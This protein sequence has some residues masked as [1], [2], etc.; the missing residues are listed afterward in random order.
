VPEDK[1]RPDITPKGLLIAEVTLQANGIQDLADQ[2]PDIVK[3]AV[4]QDLR[5]HVRIEFGGGKPPAPE[6]VDQLNGLLAE[7]SDELKLK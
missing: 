7:V 1:E 5:F 4:G 2:I 3:A 6:T